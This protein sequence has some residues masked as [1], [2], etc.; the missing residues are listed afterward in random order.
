MCNK[1]VITGFLSCLPLYGIV[2][3]GTD[4]NSALVSYGQV[5]NGVQMTGVAMITSSIG[6]CTGTLLMDSFSVLTAGHCVT[7]SFGSG[8]ATGIT[9]SF[10]GPGGLVAQSVS[11]VR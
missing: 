8:I 2:V 11:M 5:V 4:P 1:L 6:G 7:S 9:V 10:L 3:A